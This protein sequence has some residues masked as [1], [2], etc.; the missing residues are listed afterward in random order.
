MKRHH[1][2]LAVIVSRLIFTLPEVVLVLVFS[3]LVFGVTSAGGYLPILLLIVLGAVQF[4]GIG[5]LVASRATTIETVSGLMNAVMLPMYIASGVFFANERFPDA[6]QPV[7]RLLPLTPL[8]HALRSV[9][10][11]GAGLLSLGG[12][13]ALIVAWGGV[14][15]A[16]AIKWFRWN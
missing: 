9:M 5:L 15:L 13:L 12:D 6:V 7:L 16:L 4:S 8:I 11:E 14:T 3:Q 10:L 1:F 2:L